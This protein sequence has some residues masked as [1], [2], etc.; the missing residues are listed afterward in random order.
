MTVFVFFFKT[1]PSMHTFFGFYDI[2][3]MLPIKQIQ[4]LI[5]IYKY[6]GGELMKKNFRLPSKDGK[7]QLH[8]VMW[9][10]KEPVRAVVQ[11]SHGMVEYIERYEEFAEYANAHGILVVGND[12]LGHGH[13]AQNEQELGYFCKRHMSKTVV[14]DLHRV[15]KAT[16]KQYPDVPYFLLG[17]SMGS[18]LA[19]RYLMT[20]G[21][22]L[23]GA[24][25]CGTGR[26]LPPVLTFGRMVENVMERVKG[27]DYRSKVFDRMVFGTYNRKVEHPVGENDWICS[28]PEVVEKKNGEIHGSFIFTLNGFRTLFDTI[29]Y[30]QQPAHINRI[31]KKLPLFFIAGSE[32][33]VGDYGRGV[34]EVYECYRKAGIKN[35]AIKLYEGDRHEIFN[36]EDRQEVFE[37]VMDWLQRQ[38]ERLS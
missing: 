18:F 2:L 21:K 30:I 19:R 37:D 22:E 32:D 15:T 6:R 13:T 27:E 20:Y 31:P 11:I 23:S 33:P 3:Y 7:H 8:V 26:Q 14:A 36:E 25:L 5:G 24:I 28:V 29:A 16:K 12:H 9:I 17:H 38:M 10:P 35:L 4:V 34:Q 1:F